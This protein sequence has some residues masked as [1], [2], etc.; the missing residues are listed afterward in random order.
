MSATFGGRLVLDVNGGGACCLY[1]L[2]GPL[3]VKGGRPE[4]SVDVDQK[5]ELARTGDPLD[6][7]HYVVE[8]RDAEIGQAVG[9]ESKK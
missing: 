2:D 6:V 4:A 1:L 3:N 7:F 9:F 5:G 8:S